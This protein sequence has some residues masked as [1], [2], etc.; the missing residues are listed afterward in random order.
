MR[1]GAVCR[2]RMGIGIFGVAGFDFEAM[3]HAPNL[4]L[5][6]FGQSV[7]PADDDLVPV[8]ADSNIQTLGRLTNLAR[9]QLHGK[10]SNDGLNGAL[11]TLPELQ[12]LW[13]ATSNISN[14]SNVEG[15]RRMRWL[16]LSDNPHLEDIRPI[17]SLTDL[18]VLHL[19]NT[20][21]VDLAPLADLRCALSLPL[22][23]VPLRTIVLE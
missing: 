23:V 5:F 12:H 2:R 20:S 18:R 10:F 9:L 8:I 4:R 1:G 3:S 22:V 16:W 14:I 17:Q 6:D 19:D 11:A 15:C 13:V 7:D 21:V